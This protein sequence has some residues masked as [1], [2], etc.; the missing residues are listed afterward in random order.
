MAE[1]MAMILFSGTV[2]KLMAGSIMAGGAVAMGMD[3]D[4]FVTFW[5]L[6][7][8]RKDMAEKNQRMSQD[9]AEMIP[10][11]GKAMAAK[12]M[13]SW[14]ENLKKVKGLGNVKIHVCSMMSD[15]MEWKKTDFVDL[16]DDVIGVGSFIDMAKEAK[17]TLFI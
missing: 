2:D 16:V 11:F 17:M 10:Q 12:K 13:P 8:F 6:V 3:V 15:V 7:A 9:F 1:K 5:G 4:I 14:I